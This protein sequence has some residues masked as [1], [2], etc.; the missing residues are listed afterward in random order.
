M[1]GR[2]G[3]RIGLDAYPVNVPAQGIWTLNE[4]YYETRFNTWPVVKRIKKTSFAI[5][6][7]KIYPTANFALVAVRLKL[8]KPFIVTPGDVE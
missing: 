3:G 6:S 2:R 4:I 7:F 5:D 8:A 1:N